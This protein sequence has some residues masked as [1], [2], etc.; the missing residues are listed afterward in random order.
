MVLCVC[1][2]VIFLVC[3]VHND[4][5]KNDEL[6]LLDDRTLDGLRMMG[7]FGLQVPE[8]YGQ[9]PYNFCAVVT[10]IMPY[11]SRHIPCAQKART[12]KN[13]SNAAH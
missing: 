6:G 5:L 10:F 9:T 12:C 7:A 1:K 2:C 13:T 3:Q 4:P 8:G 11:G